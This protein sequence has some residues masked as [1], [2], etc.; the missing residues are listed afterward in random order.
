MWD[1]VRQNLNDIVV[2]ATVLAFLLSIMVLA[3]SAFRYV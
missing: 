3:F 1:W 2:A